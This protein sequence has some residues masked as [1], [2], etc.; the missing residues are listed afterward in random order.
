[1]KAR[2]Q[3]RQRNQGKGEKFGEVS[4]GI[5]KEG[6]TVRERERER[7]TDRQTN[8]HRDRK[9]QNENR[10]THK[11]TSKQTNKQKLITDIHSKT[12]IIK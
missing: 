2:W 4:R 12:E 10:Q 7:Q 8:I 6:E 1:M 5:V 11:Q 3:R 9:R